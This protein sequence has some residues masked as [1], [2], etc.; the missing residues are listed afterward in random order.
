MLAQEAIDIL[1]EETAGD[2]EARLAPLGARLAL[3]VIDRMQQGPGSG[4]KQDPAQVTRAPKLKKEHGLIDWTKDGEQVCRQVRA[5]EPWPKAYPWLHRQGQPP[6]R[7]IVNKAVVFNV[8]RVGNEPPPHTGLVFGGGS[9]NLLVVATGTD[10]H[11]L[12]Q[13]LQPAG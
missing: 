3:E 7:V 2:L 11:V 1:P 8:Y 12:V 10:R 9:E 13:E 6:L 4:V 5:R